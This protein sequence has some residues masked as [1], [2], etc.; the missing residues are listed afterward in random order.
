M[1]HHASKAEKAPKDSN[2]GLFKLIGPNGPTLALE[3]IF[4]VRS[5]KKHASS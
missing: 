2:E 5:K 1:S 4:N 3:V